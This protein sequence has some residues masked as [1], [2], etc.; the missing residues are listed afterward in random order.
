MNKSACSFAIAQWKS[1]F[2]KKINT[3]IDEKISKEDLFFAYNSLVCFCE[4]THKD[5]SKVD[6]EL[7]SLLLKDLID[8]D[9][10]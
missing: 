1:K 9:M 2:P 3:F 4:I 7:V 10:E 5:Y 8:D 6:S